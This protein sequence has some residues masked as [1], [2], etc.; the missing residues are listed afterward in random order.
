MPEEVPEW[1]NPPPVEAPHPD[2]KTSIIKLE[3]SNDI[4]GR[5]KE[6]ALRTPLFQAWT[7]LHGCPPPI[8]N[9]SI[10]DSDSLKPT[11][12]TL[13]E[14]TSCFRG[15]NRPINTQ[16][17]GSEVITYVLKPEATVRYE[18]RMGAP[19]RAQS[20]KNDYVLTVQIVLNTSLQ[21]EGSDIDG[22]VTRLEVVEC[23]AAN[24]ELPK[25]HSSRYGDRLW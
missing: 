20:L 5:G 11:Y 21:K 24:D 8:K 14:A 23:D 1:Q 13:N 6:N 12:Q 22:L 25:N 7:H 15:I 16:K 3:I 10:L 19:I 18:P 2:E 9:V 4:V 17:N